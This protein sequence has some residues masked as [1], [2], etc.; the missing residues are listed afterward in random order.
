MDDC[1]DSLGTASY[2]TTLNFN[3]GY[4][5]VELAEGDCHKTAFMNHGGTFQFK[6]I[7]LSLC[8]APATFQSALDIIFYGYHWNACLAYLDDVIIFSNSFEDHLEHVAQ[9]LSVLQ[10]AVLSLK[11][12]K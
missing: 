12:P 10:L 4:C 5:Q 1:L 3:S 2:F 8:N 11:L 7:P 9:V 6:R